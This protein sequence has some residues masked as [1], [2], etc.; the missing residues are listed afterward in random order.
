[1][2]IGIKFEDVSS[3]KK[4]LKVEVPSEIALEK[5]D[6][7]ANEYRKHARLSGFRPGKAPVALVK[8]HFRT[9]IR[10]DVIQKLI[11]ESYNE[12]IKQQGVEPLGDPNLENFTFEEGQ[13]LV[14]EA[15][16][17]IHP[18]IKLPKYKGLKISVE[19]KTVTDEDVENE[20]E[21]LRDKH[22]QLLA[23][24]GRPVEKDDYVVVDLHGEYLDIT[25]G[26]KAQDPIDDENIVVQVGHGHTHEAFSQSLMGMSMEQTKE[27]EVDY[28]DDYPE[29]KLAGHKV[30]FNIKVNEIKSKKLPELNDEFAKDLGEFDTLEQLYS[31]IREGLAGQREDSRE[32]ELRSQLIS[33]LVEGTSFEVPE[34]L[35]ESRIDSILQDMAHRM[36]HQGIDPMKA[37]MD[38]S[39][40]R[41]DLHPEAEKQVRGNL[42]LE[43]IA[44][45]EDVQVL[46]DELDVEIGKMADS[47]GQP[48]E[49]VRQYFQQEQHVEGLKQQ[50]IQQKTLDYLM[51]N[52][53]VK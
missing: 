3:V 12:A 40:I 22:S 18:E 9:K 2:D 35:V 1:M 20:L 21:R 16:F 4:R 27:F 36:A 23:V 52:S 28:A 17:E 25:E 30:C 37:N 39:K 41:S 33:Q 19:Q 31:K 53:K 48:V 10:D 24:E 45:K 29:D 46:S 32:S 26:E 38:W 13:P 6:Q 7:V 43:E 51:Q 44:I 47:M 14:Y 5:M 50:I 34:T 42:I 11:P 15:N 49:K 8:R